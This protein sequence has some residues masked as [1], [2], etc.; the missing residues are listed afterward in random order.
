MLSEPKNESKWPIWS[1]R[2]TFWP[3]LNW[4]LRKWNVCRVMIT[5]SRRLAKTGCYIFQV[6]GS[7]EVAEHQQPKFYPLVNVYKKLWKITMLSMGKSTISMAIFKFA[8]CECL[9]GRVSC[10]WKVLKSHGIPLSFDVQ[11]WQS[12]SQSPKPGHRGKDRSVS[13]PKLGT[14]TG[15]TSGRSA[16]LAVTNHLQTP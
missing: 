5:C 6:M 4:R 12:W 16:P 15:L 3:R 1:E 8:N 2:T 10:P 7:N 11:P 14:E 9:P 13:K